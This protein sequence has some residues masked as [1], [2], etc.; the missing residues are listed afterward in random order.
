[1]IGCFNTAIGYHPMRLSVTSV[2]IVPLEEASIPQ[3]DLSLCGYGMALLEITIS[4]A[5]IP[6]KDLSLCGAPPVNRN[7]RLSELQYRKRISPYAATGLVAYAEGLLW[8]QYRKRISPY[9]ALF[10]FVTPLSFLGF[11]TAIGYHPM[12]HLRLIPESMLDS[13]LQYRN[14]VSPHAA[15]NRI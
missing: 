4:L 7:K 3:K 14:R 15:S 1:M 5:S 8:L 9:A 10:S 11:N 2:W 6:Q 12:R 13:G